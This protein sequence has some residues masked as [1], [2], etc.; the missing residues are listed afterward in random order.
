MNAREVFTAAMTREDPLERTA[1]IRQACAGDAN[2]QHEVELLLDRTVSLDGSHSEPRA[3]LIGG[4]DTQID[5]YRLMEPLGSGGM[6]VVYLAEQQHPVRRHVALKIIKPGMDTEMVIARF[7]AERQALALMDHPHIAK[8]LDAGA[9]TTGRP[10][11]V[12]ELVEGI[13]ITTHCDAQRL[14]V[15]ERLEL[16]IQVCQAVQHAHQK[17]IIHRDIKPSNILVTLY[18][19]KPSPKVID[20]G[21]AKAIKDDPSERPLYTRVGS[22]VGTT[23]YMSPEQ[24]G[25]L[26]IDTRTDVY[27]LGI[28]LYEL[29]TGTSPLIP[30]AL[31]TLHESELLRRIREEEPPRPSVRL[32]SDSQSLRT[33]AEGRGVTPAKL[34]S[35]VRGD[36][37]WIVMKAIEK[38][39]A[40]RYATANALARDLER[41]L[42]TEPVEA[43]PPS[44]TYKLRKFARRHRLMLTTAAS[45]LVL[46]VAAAAISTWQ[47]LRA[48]QERDRALAAIGEA[49]TQQLVGFALE[50]FSEDPE[51]SIALAMH[52][53]NATRSLDGAVSPTAAAV[54]HSAILASHA[55]LTFRGHTMPV[56]SV[57]F[58]PDGA[59]VASGS[60]D[61]FVKLWEPATGREL[62]SL[63]HP[64]WVWSVAFSPDGQRLATGGADK[65]ARLWDPRT[66]RELL[67][68]PGHK[69]SINAVTFSPD[70]KRLATA[71]VD[72]TARIWNAESGKEWATFS[73]HKAPVNAVAFSPDG[74]LAAS[75][76]TDGAAFIWDTA[77]GKTRLTLSRQE[78]NI[79]AVAFSSDGKRITLGC[80]DSAVR[81]FNAST[82][83]E[84]ATLRGGRGQV[85]S[86]AFSPDGNRIAAGGMDI[87]L[88]DF[89][90]GQEVM[91]LRGHRGAVYGIAFSPDGERLSSASF[92]RSVKVW[93]ISPGAELRTIRIDKRPGS[94]ITVSSDGSRIAIADADNT[95]QLWD[96]ADGRPIGRLQGHSGR[97]SDFAWIPEN[98]QVATASYDGT[99]R[100]WDIATGREL[101]VFRGHSN[102]IGGIAV[103]SDRKLIATAGY[104]KT[105]R[106]WDAS[107]GQ[108]LKILTGHG[109]GVV[110][111]EFSPDVSRLASISRDKTARIW[112]VATGRELH[113][114]KG[115]TDSLWTVTFSPNNK[116]L[117]TGGFDNTARL[118]DVE[119]GRELFVFRD[120]ENGILDAAFSHDGNLAATSSLD[121]T[122]KLWAPE[123]GE[124]FLTLRGHRAPVASVRFTPDG[125]RFITADL[126]GVVQVY[127][128]DMDDL[129]NLARSRVTRALTPAEC[130]RYF[131]TETCPALP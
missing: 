112:D 62:L 96:T 108:E 126:E 43:S 74:R 93:S 114:L 105:V 40:Q 18:D 80:R 32:A 59:S 83:N 31:A 118:W 66:G 11:F 17:G 26:D 22:V 86:L 102:R 65:V 54:L 120:H 82:G 122:V 107:S 35:T 116:H 76:D 90:T 50:S 127:A 119:S 24:A 44:A 128:L 45:F 98:D 48:N 53:V 30:D 12:M 51:R 27:S 19:G 4:P 42:N 47:A 36:L 34:L 121:R 103:S 73:G 109:D 131:R 125:K 89:N 88:W 81:L 25:G 104:D 72:G 55:R 87:R 92:D 56:R 63:R 41:Y 21:L 2:L 69:H 20:F 84:E 94:G 68:L 5:N 33:V 124:E 95:A 14:G 123:T 28:V 15:N 99:A 9:T 70:G 29:L 10:Y 60:D 106:L 71:S 61:G 67:A 130:R 129:L 7:E 38:D 115:H 8:V 117:L 75:A 58:S 3:S 6:G 37:E 1:F 111:V 16:F 57:A 39:R 100:L 49:R 52:A 79:G 97:V 101:R 77:T 91:A 64:D 110:E 78:G 85:L 113:T 46:L 23:R 13:P